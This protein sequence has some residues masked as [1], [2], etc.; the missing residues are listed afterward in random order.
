MNLTDKEFEKLNIILNEKSIVDKLMLELEPYDIKQ[1]VELV[2]S[3]FI[4]YNSELEVKKYT[5]HVYKNKN[6]VKEANVVEIREM[7]IHN[8]SIAGFNKVFKE[9]SLVADGEFFFKKILIRPFL[10]NGVPKIFKKEGDY[11][12]LNLGYI[13]E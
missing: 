1:N 7:K 11:T 8:E 2:S 3:H 4:K 13:T 12:H 6:V 5:P 9:L 10:I